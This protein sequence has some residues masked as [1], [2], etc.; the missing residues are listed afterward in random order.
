MNSSARRISK[1]KTKTKTKTKKQ[2]QTFPIKKKKQNKTKPGAATPVPR[3]TLLQQPKDRERRSFLRWVARS[4]PPEGKS[5]PERPNG[6]RG[7]E[8][9]SP[10]V[11]TAAA[12]L[13]SVLQK[14]KKKK[15]KN[16]PLLKFP[17]KTPLW[18]TEA[19]ALSLFGPSADAARDRIAPEAEQT[20]KQP[21]LHLSLNLF[22]AYKV[23]RLLWV[24]I[25]RGS[26]N[27]KTT[28][29]FSRQNL[30]QDDDQAPSLQNQA[31]VTAELDGMCNTDLLPAA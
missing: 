31:T 3:P 20:K 8:G 25:L 21:K 13:R 5:E 22:S 10:P 9:A 1:N 19:L 4:V 23:C 2:T 14:K 17:L 26:S 27:E 11:A 29:D 15:K 28:R 12:A 30:P 16:R 24:S 6:D 7:S 18:E